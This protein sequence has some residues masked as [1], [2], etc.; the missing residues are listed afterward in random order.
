MNPRADTADYRQLFLDGVPFLDLRS[1][2]EFAHGAFPTAHNLPLMSDQERA[3]VGTC[4]KRRGQAAAIAL[5]HRLVSGAERERRVAAWCEFARSHP[6]GYLYC[7][8][9]GLRSQTVQQWL[10]DEGIAYPRVSGG[11]KAL[12]RF[13]LDELEHSLARARLVLISGR[14]G[15]GKTRVVTA[16]ERAVDLEGLARHRGSSFGHLPE[17]QPSQVDF[18]NSVSIALLQLLARGDDGPVYLEDEGRLIGRL[19]LPENLLEQ[20][21]RA[22]MAVVEESLAQRVEIILQDYVV[23]LARRYGESHGPAA[24]AELH[25]EQLLESLDRIRKRLGGERHRDIRGLMQQAFAVQAATGD[26]E[27]HRAWIA[28]LLETYY[29]PMYNYQLSRHSGEMLFRGDRAA[30]IAW[31]G[32]Q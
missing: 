17:G 24:G 30:V 23:D 27:A 19:A 3:A 2:G 28:A 13:L 7:W 9:G 26:I 10:A 21:Q 14:T 16:L 22:P 29:D 31:A 15:T 4:Y 20:M 18:E 1:P 11:Y 5:G 12:R 8:R 32:G 6:G 25:R